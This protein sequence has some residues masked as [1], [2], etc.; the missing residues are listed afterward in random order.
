[1]VLTGEG[2]DEMLGG[3]PK[4]RAEGWVRLYQ[5][6]IPR[7]LHDV[8]VSPLVRALPYG[9]RRLKILASAAGERDASTR[10]RTW[11]GGITGAERDALLGRQMSPA[12]PDC[13][14]FS[15]GCS[16]AL[17]RSLFFDQTSW[18]P[19][20]LLE[21]GDRMMMA[22]S[23]EG[24]MPFMDTELATLCARMPD[25]FLLGERGGK[26]V[27]RAAMRSVLPPEILGR[28]KIGFRVPVHAWVRGRYS[29][30]LRDMLTGGGSQVA[31]ICD[32][33]ELQRLTD[34]H[35]AGRRNNERILW[36]LANLEMFLR[37][38]RPSGLPSRLGSSIRS[39]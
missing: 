1:M 14:P 34:E 27:L 32:R 2:S 36:T 38:F 3:Y 28:R 19:D 39:T 11:F 4:H 7:G 13:L 15:L 33:A 8:V 18:L 6:L 24:R 31:H 9:S 5:R 10:L 23:I 21:R 30:L 25:R 12:P 26:A 22:G 29:D 37:A 35:I 16:S 20:N 17:R